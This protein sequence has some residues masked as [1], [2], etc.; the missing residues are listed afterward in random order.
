MNFPMYYGKIKN[1][2]NHQSE[3]VSIVVKKIFELKMGSVKY[4]QIK[5]L[6]N[7]SDVQTN[8]VK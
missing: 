6:G 3:N 8:Q 2:P 4:H 5:Q 7:F 1:G